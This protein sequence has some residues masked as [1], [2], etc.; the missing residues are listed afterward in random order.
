[1][2]H[3]NVAN[4]DSTQNKIGYDKVIYIKMRMLEQGNHNNNVFKFHIVLTVFSS[5]A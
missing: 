3:V 2:V 4:S 5:A 1:M